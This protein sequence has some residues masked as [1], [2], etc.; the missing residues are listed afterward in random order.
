MHTHGGASGEVKLVL[1]MSLRLGLC[2]CL[3][4]LHLSEALEGVFAGDVV[5]VSALDFGPSY[6][7]V[8]TESWRGRVRGRVKHRGNSKEKRVRTLVGVAVIPEPPIPQHIEAF[9]FKFGFTGPLHRTFSGGNARGNELGSLVFV[10]HSV[11]KDACLCV[12][13]RTDVWHHALTCFFLIFPYV[14]HPPHPKNAAPPET[15]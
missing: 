11:N 3:L 13:S 9:T 12:L 1:H 14:W 5:V 7:A 8:V 10:G 4:V 15:F 6:M 2:L